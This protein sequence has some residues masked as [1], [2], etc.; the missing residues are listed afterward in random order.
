ML[1]N[2]HNKYMKIG[3]NLK[4]ILA[5]PAGISGFC[6]SWDWIAES[7]KAS[8]L[9]AHFIGL[10]LAGLIGYKIYSKLNK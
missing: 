3:N 8:R 1:K 5:Y 10:S 9:P 6:F 2:R 4:R 7:L